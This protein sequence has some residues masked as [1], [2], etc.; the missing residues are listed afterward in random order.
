MVEIIGV[1]NV[2]DEKDVTLIEIKV[3]KKYD[4]FDVGDFTQEQ[5]GV[6][7]DSWQVPSGEK[8]LDENGVNVIGD[9]FKPPSQYYNTTR[10]VFFIYYLDTKKKLI[11][12][13]GELKLPEK[14]VMPTRLNEIINFESP[15]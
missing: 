13:F 4:E 12:P 15:E 3:N 8:Y 2:S 7:P 6:S 5:D 1:Y 9:Y 10:L 11:T 14:I